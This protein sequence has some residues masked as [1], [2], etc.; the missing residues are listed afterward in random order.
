MTEEGEKR[1]GQIVTEEN[2]P[3]EG[4]DV[5]IVDKGED[6]LEKMD[7][8]ADQLQERVEVLEK[9]L[10]KKRAEIGKLEDSDKKS[11]LEKRVDSLERRLK[12][13]KLEQESFTNI[14][15]LLEEAKEIGDTLDDRETEEGTLRMPPDWTDH[16]QLEDEDL[17]EAQ[18]VE[19]IEGRFDPDKQLDEI[20]E[21]V[22]EIFGFREHEGGLVGEFLEK[23]SKKE[24]KKLKLELS[25]QHI[26]SKRK[27][28]DAI[29]EKIGE[30]EGRESSQLGSDQEVD[31]IINEIREE[32]VPGEDVEYA[33]ELLGMS[34]IDSEP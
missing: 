32:L 17:E 24:L 6:S 25:K 30:F 10:E 2:Q 18:Q 26:P 13:I 28:A 14:L 11:A 33:L 3:N 29:F 4:E 8:K 20:L 12:R 7:R 22:D 15:D 23:L 21:R 34:E 19:E 27:I 16:P 1:K 5:E 9:K 31:D